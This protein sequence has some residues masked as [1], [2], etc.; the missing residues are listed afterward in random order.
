MIA[1]VRYT[2][3]TTIHGQRYLAP[4]LLFFAGVGIS[5]G[6][7][8]GPLPGVY[9]LNA[10][11]LLV[12]VTWVTMAVISVE[13][14]THRAITVV[15]ARGPVKVLAA[16]IVVSALL[17]VGLT[18]IGLGLPLAMHPRPVT[19]ADLPAGALAHLLCAAFG[20]AFGLVCSRLVIRRQGYALLAALFL[21]TAA[22]LTTGSPPNTLFK[23]MANTSNAAD[24]LPT[25]AALL[26]LGLAVLALA[27]AL[28]H[29][30]S[31]R[32]D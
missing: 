15:A 6:S 29:I 4:V 9:A 20:L 14:P 13:D 7:D 27:A 1:L 26:P 23:R 22:L 25:A 11:I 2:L 18:I 5:A 3:A 31:V 8:S 24:I 32:R 21:V 16:A 19:A 17:A 12:C 30:V 10:G 28:T